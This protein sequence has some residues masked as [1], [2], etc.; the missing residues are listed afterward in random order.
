[1]VLDIYLNLP[2]EYYLEI[3]LRTLRCM[4][5][6]VDREKYNFEGKQLSKLVF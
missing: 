3:P 6:A 4:T 5:I 1:M 2:E